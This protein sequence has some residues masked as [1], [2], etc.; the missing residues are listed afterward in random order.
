MRVIDF[1]HRACAQSPLLKFVQLMSESKMKFIQRQNAA[2]V[3]PVMRKQNKTL[4]R[5]K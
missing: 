5:I 2:S 1:Y 3:Y 4:T